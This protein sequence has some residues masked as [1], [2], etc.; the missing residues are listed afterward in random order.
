M[1]VYRLKKKRNYLRQVGN[2][3]KKWHTLFKWL[4]YSFFGALTLFFAL[5]FIISA[6]SDFISPERYVF[7]AY[8]GLFFPF[9]LL[10]NLIF[11]FYWIIMKKWLI[12]LFLLSAFAICWKPITV[13]CPFHLK[14]KELPRE[15]LIKILS[16][17][18]MSFAYK[19]HTKED[20]NKIIQFIAESEADIVCLQEYMVSARPNLMSSKAVADALSMY[21][22]ITEL[23]FSTPDSKSYK[24]G[25]ALLSKF[26]ILSSR[27]IEL[28]SSPYN[29]A[30]IHEINVRGKKVTVVNN[31]LESFKL[32]AEDRSKYS[33]MITRV[34]LELFDELRGAIQQ[35]LGQAFRIRAKQAERIADEIRHANGCYTI[36]CGD[37][38]DT[39][40]SYVHRTILGPLTDAYAESGFGVGISYNQNYFFFRIDHIFHS[41]G[42]V[43]YNC[44]VDT[45]VKLSDHYPISCYLKLN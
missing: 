30:A 8:T 19:D 26:P 22:Y 9:L 24:Y 32:T 1:K 3:K 18:V 7:F 25:L 15:E 6:H 44:R 38:N 16:Y 45:R 29:G 40:L 17:N 39:P 5:F 28:H 11:L 4:Y 37:F 31:H 2:K 34:S 20:A 41:A 36:I 35:K 10:I 23:F 14:T 12:S 27:K 33:D 13:F 43:A 21:P 42:M